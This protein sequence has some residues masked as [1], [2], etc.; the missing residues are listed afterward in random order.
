MHSR[1][2]TVTCTEHWP[3]HLPERLGVPFPGCP[4]TQ[5]PGANRHRD[6]TGTR[7]PWVGAVALGVALALVAPASRA[8]EA[9]QERMPLTAEAMWE[10]ARLGPPSI[11]SDGRWVALSVTRYDVKGNKGLSALW[12]VPAGG[13]TARQLTTHEGSNTGPVFSPDGRWI[14]FLSKRGDDEAPQV[15]LIATDGGEAQRLTTVPGGAEALKWFPDSRRVAFA[16]WTFPEWRGFED[17]ARRL[18]ERKDSKVTAR[19][20]DRAPVRYWDT[21]LDG[22]VP[23]LFTVGIEGGEPRPVTPGSGVALGYRGESG[24]GANANEYDISPDGKE[25]VL[26]ADSD[27]TGVDP[28]HDLYVVPSA[29]GPAMNLTPDNPADDGLPRWSPD[30]RAVA[31]ARMAKRRFYAE[32]NRLAVLERAT[33]KSRVLTESWDRSVGPLVWTPNGKS[34]LTAVDEGGVHRIF[35]VDA[36]TGTPVPVT[37]SLSFSNLTLA[38]NGAAVAFRQGI[39][40]PPTLV[41]VDLAS[42]AAR[43]ISSFNRAALASVEMGRYESVTIP[44]AAGHPV[45]MWVV[46]PPGFD[47]RRKYPLLMLLHGGPHVALNDLFHWRWN[48]EVFAGWGYVVAWHNFHGSPGFGQAFVE[49]IRS[50]WATLPAEDTL[51]AARWFASRPWIDPQR[52][53]AAGGSYGGYLAG[54]LLGMEHPFRTLVAH[55]GVHD[56]RAQYAAD[57]GAQRKDIPEFWEDDA[58]YRSMSPILGASRFRTPVLLT[59]GGRD[60]RVPD[61]QTFEL[62]NV[63]QNR[64]VESRLVYYPDEN[65][66]ILKPQNSLHWYR[67]VREWLREHVGE[68]PTPPVAAK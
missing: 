33:G 35:R 44:G 39:A 67:T 68:G 27:R 13:G 37:G 57:Y 51:S 38:R 41:Q 23:H 2:K 3:S 40:E 61:A 49:S 25:I 42:G 62:F 21:W 11:S 6:G 56:G 8:A 46:Y 22:L 45:Q 60:L 30:G 12:L 5:S 16:T 7:R 47:P 55:A 1:A 15:Y 50:D 58:V 10:L 14:A 17:L 31:Y 26:S 63:L 18:K 19:V 24:F 66:W 43:E 52:M 28:N 9:T 64:G 29:G 4:E 48:A 53:A 36:S 34:I 54:L 20:W 59:A 32:R 65:H